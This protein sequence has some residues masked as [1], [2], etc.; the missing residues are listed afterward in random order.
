MSEAAEGFATWWH[1][2]PLEAGLAHAYAVEPR[3]RLD[4]DGQRLELLEHALLGRM[5]AVDG[6]LVW[7]ELD[8]TLRE[9]LVRVPL[10]AHPGDAL[11]VLV[12]GAGAAVPEVLAHGHV[13]TVVHWQAAAALTA[14]LAEAGAEPEAPGPRLERTLAA[15]AGRFDVIVLEDPLP[16]GVTAAELAARLDDGGVV[17]A[18]A[19]SLLTW[20]RPCRRPGASARL[21]EALRE[22][23][24]APVR[25]EW[26]ASSPH[27][28]GG[29]HGFEAV[30]RPGAPTLATPRRTVPGRCYD[31]TVHEAAFA[32]PPW[33]CLRERRDDAP[34]ELDAR[35]WWHEQTHRT[36]ITQALSLR[37]ELAEQSEWQHI[38]I[39][40]HERFGTVLALDGTVQGSTADE[41]VYHELAVHVPLLGR[42]RAQVSALVVGGGDGGIVRELLRHDFVHRV[43][44][45]EIDPRVIAISNARFGIQ[46]DI[47]DPRVE[48]HVMDAAIYLERAAARGERFELVIV[49]ATDSTTPSFSLWSDAFFANL[50]ACTAPDGVCID[51][52]ILVGGRVPQLSRDW[53]GRPLEDVRRS[54]RFF[55]DMQC[56]HTVVPL[57]P[58]GCFCFFAY[59]HAPLDLSTPVRAYEGRHYSPAVHRGAFALPP[60]LRQAVSAARG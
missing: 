29:F 23:I 46:P 60:W 20:P 43:V 36:G 33:W 45:V 24:E 32:L 39:L 37:S 48:T 44:M 12:V 58:A 4:H 38:E 54:A 22:H 17:V 51:S 53:Q 19:P 30:G 5:V 28:A 27:A 11:R 40:H 35:A 50:A 49:D 52:D 1:E 47:A 7:I 3:R 10:C 59:G 15:P 55:A 9:L 18:G 13:A 16:P 14:L 56:F 42:P 26:L 41:C 6:R 34:T 25:A 31:E 2:Q 57:Y 21:L 8:A